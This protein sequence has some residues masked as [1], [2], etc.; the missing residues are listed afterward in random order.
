MKRAPKKRRAP[1]T[2]RQ[3]AE[4]RKQYYTARWGRVRKQVLARDHYL[5]RECGEPGN[6][7]DHVLRAEERPELFWQLENLQTLCRTCHSRK[8]QRGE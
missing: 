5:C 1:T 8:T 4:N 6:Q 2:R 3:N 7:V